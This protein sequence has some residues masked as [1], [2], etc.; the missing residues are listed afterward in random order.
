M[1]CRGENVEE[2]FMRTASLIFQSVQD[3]TVDV[4]SDGGEKKNALKKRFF[5]FSIQF[6]HNKIF[7]LHCG[8]RDEAH[9]CGAGRY[10]S[11]ARK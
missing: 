7:C 6:K 5:A 10:A 8:R 9:E 2:A 1:L 4:S 3:G 11:G